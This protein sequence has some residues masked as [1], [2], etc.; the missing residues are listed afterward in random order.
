M[1]KLF[2]ATPAYGH[3]VFIPYVEGL[4]KFTSGVNPSDLDIET[5]IH[6]HAGSAL[7]TQARNNCVAHFLR[8]DCTKLLFIDADI[9][10]EPEDIWRLLRK[11]EDVVLSPYVIKTIKPKKNLNMVVHY[12]DPD[13]INVTA[14][15]FAEIKGGPAGFMMIK[16]NVFET[17]HESFPDKKQ[18][19][20]HIVD[21]EVTT[22]ED[23]YTY[24]DCAIDP[25]EGC[26]GED[27]AFCFLWKSIGGK[28]FCDTQAKLIHCGM[29][30]FSGVLTDTLSEKPS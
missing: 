30:Q 10:F 12:D 20:R 24:F 18:P 4:V 6:L 13:T 23:Y 26:I 3:K 19:L 17:L 8:T 7:V 27:L 28:I 21:G 29:H 9:G 11:D 2:I 14:D 25:D 5:K 22:E 1:E 16:R 15:G